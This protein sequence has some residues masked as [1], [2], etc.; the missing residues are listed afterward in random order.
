M[1]ALK[2]KDGIM[3]S[4]DTLASYGSLARFKDIQRLKPVGEF[5]V[6][7]AGGDMSDFQYLEKTLE[8][9]VYVP[10]RTHLRSSTRHISSHSHRFCTLRIN[11]SNTSDGHSLGPKEIYSYLSNIMYAR[12]SKMNPIWNTLLVGGVRNGERYVH[13]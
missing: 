7:G 1:L 2:F 11:E 3:M 5:T 10:A 6:V 12:R 8:S 4:A 13:V 9:A